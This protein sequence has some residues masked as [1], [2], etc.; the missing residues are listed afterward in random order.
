MV[1]FAKIIGY[2]SGVSLI[3]PELETGSLV[4]TLMLIHILDCILCSIIARHSGRK[5]AAW[6]LVGLTLGVWGVLPLL[7][8]PAKKKNSLTTTRQGDNATC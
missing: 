1:D 4:P 5:P 8:L 3:D 7:L 6:G 2:L